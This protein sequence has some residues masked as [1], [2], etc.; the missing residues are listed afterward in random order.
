MWRYRP[1]TNYNLTLFQVW[2][3][4]SLNSNTYNRTGEIQL[5]AGNLIQPDGS[6][7]RYFFVNMSLN[8]SSRI[9]FQSGDVIGYYQP[10]N[11]LHGIW[12]IQTSGYT[13][14]I[15]TTLNPLASIDINNVEDTE[16]DH[17]PLIEVIFGK[18]TIID[19]VT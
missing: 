17:Q 14:Y 15:N 8:S 1:G 19:K 3:P 10:L 2:H 6:S 4:T 16:T 9:E 18:I 13:S 7:T 12:N 11:P 5:P